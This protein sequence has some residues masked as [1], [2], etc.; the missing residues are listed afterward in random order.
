VISAGGV[1][2]GDLFD[3]I[4][5]SAFYFPS[6]PLLLFS[7]PVAELNILPTAVGGLGACMVQDGS[8]GAKEVWTCTVSG[9]RD[10]K[11]RP[12]LHKHPTSGEERK[13][14]SFSDALCLIQVQCLLEC[15]TRV[16][17]SVGAGG[18]RYDS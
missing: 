15:C 10:L 11:I 13:A 9:N 8:P 14:V 1:G 2:G 4:S 7:Q 3:Q 6:W 12:W 17:Y 16:R 18:C 5:G